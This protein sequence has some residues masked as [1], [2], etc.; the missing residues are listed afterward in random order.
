MNSISNRPLKFL[1]LYS[2]VS[3]KLQFHHPHFGS[4]DNVWRLPT[5]SHCM[6]RK[7]DVSWTQTWDTDTDLE[8]IGY[9]YHKAISFTHAVLSCA[10]FVQFT[11]CPPILSSTKQALSPNMS[12][13]LFFP[14]SVSLP[15]PSLSFLSPN[16]QKP[17]SFSVKLQQQQKP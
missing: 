10:L 16:K 9:N 7:L 11:S 6:M 4:C 5:K 2:T 14:F 1:F 8:R 13:L 3:N 12:Y 17:L 15:T